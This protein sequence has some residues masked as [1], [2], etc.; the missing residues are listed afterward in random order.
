[1][2]Q[3]HKVCASFCSV[4]ISTVKSTLLSLSQ[5]RYFKWPDSVIPLLILWKWLSSTLFRAI[6]GKPQFQNALAVAGSG[7][8]I[9]ININRVN[10]RPI[11][12]ISHVTQA[13]AWGSAAPRRPGARTFI[14]VPRSPKRC[15]FCCSLSPRHL[16][17][18]FAIFPLLPLT[19]M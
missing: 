5:R 9:C 17:I 10:H 14:W 2:R 16:A 6:N 18:Y 8:I 4:L 15:K 3:L 12:I 1:M 13:P 19:V 7:K 11:W